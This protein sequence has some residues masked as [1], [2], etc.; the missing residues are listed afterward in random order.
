MHVLLMRIYASAGHTAMLIR[1]YNEL[2]RVLRYELD[3]EPTPATR[4][5][6]QRLLKAMV[7]PA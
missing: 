5:L 7:P 4:E 1:Q 2:T 6:Y 3:A